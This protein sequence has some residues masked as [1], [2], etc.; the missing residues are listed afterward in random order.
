[1]GALT[2]NLSGYSDDCHSAWTDQDG[3]ESSHSE[4]E[5]C[6]WGEEDKGNEY[7]PVRIVAITPNGDEVRL[8]LNFTRRCWEVTGFGFSEALVQRC[9]N[10]TRDSDD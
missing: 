5:D 3:D 4:K 9:V 8:Y 7:D 2:V 6:E 10:L 1:M